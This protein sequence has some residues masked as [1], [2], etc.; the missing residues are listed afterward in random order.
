MSSMVVRDKISPDLARMASRFRNR[1]PITEAMGVALMSVT[2]RAFSQARFRPSPWAKVKRGGQ[3][4]RKTGALAHSIRVVRATNSLVE[5]GSDRVYA[6][7]HQYGT[8][9][10]VIRARAKKAL[11]WAGA[12]HPV[13]KV[14]HP[15]L[16]ARPFFPF[17]PSG[18]P[19]RYARD[20]VHK[21]A[22]A[23]MRLM[24]PR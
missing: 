13:K 24:A 2:Q 20:L 7:F 23:K 18:T 4:L 16:A 11:F 17:T 8:D 5:V 3:P 10:Y 1:K 14:N 12:A 22:L 21:A 9:P 6:A 15:G 19:T